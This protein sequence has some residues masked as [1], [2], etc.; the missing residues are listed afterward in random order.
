M[1]NDQEI[2]KM[3]INIGG[4]PIMLT[5]PFRNQELT[6]SVEEEANNLFDTWRKNFPKRSEKA[7]LAMV[8]YRYA[9]L[10]KEL[11]IKYQEALEKAEECL[12]LAAPLPEE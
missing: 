4:E 10:Y 11:T 7:L 1:M 9:S 12:D 2:I 3:E 5:V 8:A 6:R